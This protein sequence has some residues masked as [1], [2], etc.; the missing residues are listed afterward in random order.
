[1]DWR[2][3]LAKYDRIEEDSDTISDVSDIPLLFS[4]SSS[5][6]SR[7]SVGSYRDAHPTATQHLAHVIS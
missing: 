1:M 4:S 6:D 2:K 3:E 7:S 5:L